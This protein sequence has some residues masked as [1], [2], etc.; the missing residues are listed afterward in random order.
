[1]CIICVPPLL[2]DGMH[3]ERASDGTEV[4]GLGRVVQLHDHLVTFVVGQRLV[5]VM[6]GPHALLELAPL[7][8]CLPPLHLTAT[9]QRTHALLHQLRQLIRTRVL[10]IAVQVELDE[11]SVRTRI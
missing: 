4:V 6:H 7:G 8:V 5:G 3:Q 11:R 1:M 10:L 2:L 9:A